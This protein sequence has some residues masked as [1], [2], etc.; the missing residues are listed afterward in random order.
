MAEFN[1]AYDL[2]HDH[3]GYYVNDPEDSGGETYCG[4]A[5]RYNPNWLGWRIIDLVK[6]RNDGVYNRHYLS[7]T[8]NTSLDANVRDFYFK[9]YWCP[10]LCDE[11]KVQEIANELYDTAINCGK[12][13]AVEFLQVCLNNLLKENLLQDG[14]MGDKTLRVLNNVIGK[15]DNQLLYVMMNCLQGAHYIDRMSK[16]PIKRKYARGWFKRVMI[17]KEV[18]K[19]K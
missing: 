5:R 10:L 15:E 1:K 6:S 3:E 14:E 4:I 13:K 17:T 16:S 18:M 7:V 12:S 8:E 19:G 9:Q 11:F 2:T